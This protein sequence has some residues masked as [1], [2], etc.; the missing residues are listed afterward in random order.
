MLS[1]A[2]SDGFN[3]GYDPV[4]YGV[5]EGSYATDPDGIARWVWRVACGRV[6]QAGVCPC[7]SGL[8]CCS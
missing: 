3:W 6:L 2:D 4:H 7:C 5:P 8:W 1:I